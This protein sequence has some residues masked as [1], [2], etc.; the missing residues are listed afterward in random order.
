MASNLRRA[1]A[2]GPAGVITPMGSQ[3]YRAAGNRGFFSDTRTKWVRLWADWPSL[4]PTPDKLD[5]VRVAALDA[6]I[7]RARQD[8]LRVVLTPYRFPT[9][10]NGTDQLTPEQLLA[11]M[12]DRKFQNDPD[13]KAKSLLFRYPDDL[14]AS[15]AWGRWISLLV[16][17]Y[18]KASPGRPTAD[19][20]VD[21]L[22]VCTEPNHQ[23]WPQQ[24]PSTTGVPW[25]QGTIVLGDVVANMM[26]T[27]AQIT[28]RAGGQPF[29]AGPGSADGID[30]NRLRT[31]Y[32]SLA[33]RVLAALAAAGF[34]P[35][36]GFAWSHHNYTDVTY[37]QGSGC[38]FPDVASTPSRKTTRAA[39][40]R[41][42]LVNRWAGWPA[43]D[44]AAPQV[45]I[46]ESGVTLTNVAA[47]WGITDP[48][49]QRAKQAEL[50]RRNFER[51]GNDAE[52][53]GIAMVCAY[54]W[55]TDPNY[56]SGLCDT[57]EAGGSTRTAYAT[58]R[59]LPSFA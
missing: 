14:T 54:L 13:S 36:P 3:D 30:A 15:G 31:G 20:W 41:R 9:W 55:Y 59:A 57:L 8:G 33:E 27:A 58:W 23:W 10:A 37:D 5:A 2:L 46:T 17:R 1:V 35:G 6:Q 25:S 49:A 43:G 12:P 21:F 47:R 26:I 45:L 7:A 16:N 22:E 42:R 52:G 44:A 50:I 28:A 48:A 40:M 19:T 11:T 24:A 53:A 39:D 29:L 34:K 32:H 51:M 18:G 4:M 56:D 38:T